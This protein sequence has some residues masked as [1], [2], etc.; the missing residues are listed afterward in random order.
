[1]LSVFIFKN[2]SF[3]GWIIIT[4]G[5]SFMNKKLNCMEL[6]SKMLMSVS[7]AYK[8]KWWVFRNSV[9]TYVL[10][11]CIYVHSQLHCSLNAYKWH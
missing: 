11:K 4:P 6:Y 7:I 3:D 8:E 1:M 5:N 10:T 9:C 2:I